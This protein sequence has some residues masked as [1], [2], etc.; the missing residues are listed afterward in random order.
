LAEYARIIFISYLMVIIFVGMKDLFIIN[1]LGLL[2]SYT[3]IWVRGTLPRFRYDK[4]IGLAWKSYLPG[5]LHFLCFF[6][7]LLIISVMEILW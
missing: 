3:F 4:L 2:I 1:F 6:I 5:S 7:C